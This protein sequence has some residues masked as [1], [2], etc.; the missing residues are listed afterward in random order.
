MAKGELGPFGDGGA[1]K[2][3]RQGP[4]VKNIELD[5]FPFPG[6]FGQV[7]ADLHERGLGRVIGYTTGGPKGSPSRGHAFM[8]A[9]PYR[10]GNGVT[11][12][13]EVLLVSPAQDGY[14]FVIVNPK[15]SQD[16]MIDFGKMFMP[17]REPYLF[18][19]WRPEA[20]TDA[21]SEFLDKRK[22]IAPS[23]QNQYEL[24]RH[25][26]KRNAW[27]DAVSLAEALGN[28][29]NGS[30]DRRSVEQRRDVD[31]SS[32]PFSRHSFSIF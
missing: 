16:Q 12:P 25:E 21:F 10:T 29:R 23:I 2:K 32:I 3:D 26:Q 13:K 30:A 6:A 22:R 24:Q 11:P 14:R 19:A 8:F 28:V 1:P 20:G 17:S 18:R 4:V 5:G 31:L 15:P 27:E 7:V 9:L